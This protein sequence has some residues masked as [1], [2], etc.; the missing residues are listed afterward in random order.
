VIEDIKLNSRP[1]VDWDDV[2]VTI[3]TGG[4]FTAG[5]SSPVY[6]TVKIKSSDG[7]K[8]T[9][10]VSAEQVNG[11]YQTL[12]YGAEIRFSEGSYVAADEWSVIFQSDEIM[13]GSVKSAQAYR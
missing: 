10:V 5:T 2:R 6:Y 8:M 7:I 12:A 9:T 3:S 11:N 13:I 1:G 4:T